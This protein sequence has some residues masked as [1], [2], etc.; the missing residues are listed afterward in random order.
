MTPA[1]LEL[2]TSPPD[3]D[4]SL[5]HAYWYMRLSNGE[6]IYQDDDNPN[7]NEKYTW[8]ALK[9]YISLNKLRIKHVVFKFRSNE[10][11]F[12]IKDSV[13]WIYFSKGI[14]KEWTASNQDRFFVIGWQTTPTMIERFWYKIPELIEHKTKAEELSSSNLAPEFICFMPSLVESPA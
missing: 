10:V 7:K 14:G 12:E 8:L 4:Y 9:K 5:S 6:I 1:D 11:H 13:N 3:E 2:S